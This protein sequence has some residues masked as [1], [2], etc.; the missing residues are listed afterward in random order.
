[1][2]PVEWTD[3]GWFVINSLKGPSLVQRAPNLPKSNGMKEFDDL[4]R[5]RSVLT[6]S[7]SGIPIIPA[8]L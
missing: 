6:G 7:L 3:D 5:I 4:T 8:G 1:M 2:D